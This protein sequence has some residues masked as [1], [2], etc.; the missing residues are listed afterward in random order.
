MSNDNYFSTTVAL[1]KGTQ[2]RENPTPV[3]TLSK[4]PKG[5]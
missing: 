4:K 2:E 1:K 3:N 5:K